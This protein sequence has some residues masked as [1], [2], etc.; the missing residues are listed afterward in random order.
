[1]TK[2]RRAGF[3][4]KRSRGGRKTVKRRV[5]R[6]RSRGTKRR[7]GGLGYWG[8]PN[9]T[10][11]GLRLFERGVTAGVG[12]AILW[13]YTLGHESWRGEPLS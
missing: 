7:R 9:N 3:S 12:N 5:G 10:G 8:A 6:R 4:K 1:M 2:A 11:T 13:F